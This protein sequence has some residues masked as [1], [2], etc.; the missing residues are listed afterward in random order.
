MT[1]HM[2]FSTL[3]ANSSSVGIPRLTEMGIEPFLLTAAV[4]CIIAQ[5]LV[6]RVCPHCIHG[7]DYSSKTLGLIYDAENIP[8]IIDR[9]A[10]K[11][12]KK[13][14]IKTLN[15]KDNFTFYKGSGC[16]SCGYTGYKGRIGLYEVME[17]NDDIKEVILKGGSSD[18]IE[19]A[20]IKNGMVPMLEDGIEKALSGHTSLEEIIR[21]IKT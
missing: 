2:V 3:H 5:R 13:N 9:I 12:Y 21:V 20:A 1:G 10:L 19:K 16:K 4:N 7:E 8:D 11:H 15:F 6:R 14:E 17:M 18:E